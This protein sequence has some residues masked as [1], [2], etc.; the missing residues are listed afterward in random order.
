MT[1]IASLRAWVARCAQTYTHMAPEVMRAVMP[2]SASYGNAADIF[3]FGIVISEA[4]LIIY[5]NAMTVTH[6]YNRR[7]HKKR[8]GTGHQNMTTV[9]PRKA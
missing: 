5:M 2:G 8:W 6:R 7:W 4:L 3:S 1:I 9:D